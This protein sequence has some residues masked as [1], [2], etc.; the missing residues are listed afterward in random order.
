MAAVIKEEE[1][2]VPDERPEP[3]EP[4][5][6][7]LAILAKHQEPPV[8]GDDMLEEPNV[9]GD[10]RPLG[11]WHSQ[12]LEPLRDREL[13]QERELSRERRE[14]RPLNALIR[15]A[16]GG[17][18]VEGCCDELGRISLGSDL[19]FHPPRSIGQ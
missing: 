3:G 12:I 11:G 8:G 13:S 1:L 2:D 7:D 9:L 4:P 17:T 19:Q 16:C 5:L 6:W 18:N 15:N 10:D 14:L